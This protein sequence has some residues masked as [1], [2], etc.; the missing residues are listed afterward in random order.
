[1]TYEIWSLGVLTRR[2]SSSCDCKKTQKPNIT[3]E[4]TTL[5]ID[6]PNIESV[7]I[8]SAESEYDCE[9]DEGR[10]TL[11]SSATIESHQQLTE[12]STVINFVH[13]NTES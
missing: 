8:G 5:L 10:S 2:R 3:R 9:A 7:S 6:K 1:M 13:F 12:P 11:S 4:G